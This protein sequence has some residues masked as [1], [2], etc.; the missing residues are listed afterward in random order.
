MSRFPDLMAL[1]GNGTKSSMDVARELSKALNEDIKSEQ[2]RYI[3][4][5]AYKHLPVYFTACIKGW[6]NPEIDD[7]QFGVIHPDLI[8]VDW[9]CPTRDADDMR[10]VIQKV[11]MTVQEVILRFP[12]KK[13]EFFKQLQS[14][15]LMPGGKET[16]SVLGTMIKI[17]ECWFH[18]YVR[19]SDTEVEKV[20]GVVWKYKKVLFKKMKNPNYDYTGE[21]RY[22][23]YDK[24]G[25]EKTKRSLN[26][27]EMIQIV[28]TGQLP[29]NVKAQKVYH[30]FFRQPRKPYYFFGYDQW[31]KQPYDE[32]SW[33][34][35]NL[36]NQKSMDKRGKQIEETLDSRGHHIVAKDAVTPAELEE[37]DWNDPNLDLSVAGRPAEKY[38]YVPPERPTAQEFQEL[39]NL[40][41]RMYGVAHS[42]AV[43]GE[44]KE[45]PAT[46]NQIAREGDFSAADDIVAD[47][48]T[49]ASQ[50]ISEWSMQFVKL[51]YTQDHFRW[52]MGIAGDAVYFK[53]NRNMIMDGMVI[54]V[55]A[56]GTDKLRAQ[57][58]AMDMA[59]MEMIDIHS[60]YTDMGLSDPDGRTRKLLVQ[61]ANPLAYLK[62]VAEG[63]DTAQEEAEEILAT[64]A[65]LD[66]AA[67]LNPTPSG[68][69]GAPTATQNP[70]PTNTAA[71]ATEPPAGSPPAGVL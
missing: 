2:M 68:G 3:L 10:F 35:Q 43:R 64:S 8:K 29:S 67:A 37:I 41:Q 45:G 38:L 19:H 6:W 51:R 71:V 30:N 61:K 70:T 50:W 17:S 58:N 34:E 1:P 52:L 13:D 39:G 40:R 66:P 18:E 7:Y 16:Y 12:D 24:P 14:D 33:I 25:E 20:W 21:T 59:K 42:T 62:M 28:T 36:Q 27:Q 32:T 47:T 22:F 48:I 63:H 49:S 5:I 15:G 26:F 46:N 65:P 54:K 60:F 53:L 4:G 31:G 23:A 9:T 44:V 69:A 11:P 57:N 55:K 56:S